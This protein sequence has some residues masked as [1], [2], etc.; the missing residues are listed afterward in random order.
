MGNDALRT[1]VQGISNQALDLLEKGLDGKTV[2]E[3]GQM[4]NYIRLVKQGL[5]V[6]RMNQLDVHNN[7]SF[8]LRLLAFLPKDDGSREKYIEMTNPDLKR[9]FKPVK[10]QLSKK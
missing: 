1:R 8:G 2:L 9:I 6:E 7:R 10:K 5:D 4:G 3:N